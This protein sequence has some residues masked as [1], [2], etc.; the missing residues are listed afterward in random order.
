MR[1]LSSRGRAA[2]IGAAA[3]VLGLTVLVV[4]P[5][6]ASTPYKPV[7]PASSP[8]GITPTDYPIGGQPGICGTLFPGFSGS[9][10]D[11]S[12]PKSSS[13]DA[14]GGIAFRLIVDP[15][16]QGG[17]VG[18]LWPAY[19]KGK[20]VSLSA[21][22]A[23]LVGVGINGGTD[24][25]KYDYSVLRDGFAARDGYLHAP[26]QSV[27]S[28]GM[29]TQLY[30]V[31]H[32]TLCYLPAGS[33]SGSVYRDDSQPANGS[34][35]A[36]DPGLAGWTVSLYRGGTLVGS[37]AS[38][39]DGSYSFVMPLKTGDTYTVCEAPPSGTWAQSQPSPPGPSVC[40]GSG[41]LPKGY[42]FTP[43]AATQSYTGQDFGNVPAVGYSPGP[44]GT[45]DG[46]YTIKLAA[47]KTNTFVFTAGTT[48]G[49]PFAGV[50]T[51]DQSQSSKVPVVEKIVWADPL[52]NGTPSF[53]GIRYTDTF[54]FSTS[55][56]KP[57]RYCTSDPR[58]AGSEFGLA[59]PATSGAVLPSGETSCAISIS[60]SADTGS[61][62]KFVAYVYSSVDGFR[63]TG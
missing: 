37:T 44:F 43:T 41:E 35:D 8:A 42:T 53:S 24:T 57:M 46:G 23:V 48:S 38:A 49:G 13:Y 58:S 27:D 2:A 7:P 55:N 32:L 31:S 61:N 20:Y 22:G 56:L 25:A 63:T 51:G 10:Y 29:P 12:N 33:I 30:S 15:P 17:P 19:A 59:D 40:T 5:A 54:P 9:E 50:W 4:L 3:A 16:N 39:S 34:K 62:A 36:G 6:V 21:T 28:S 47:P 26:A 52:V 18:G 45:P 1:F 14:G 60:I 11:I